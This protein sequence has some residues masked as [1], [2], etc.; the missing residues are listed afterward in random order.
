M[1]SFFQTQ[2]AADV[3]A[4][5]NKKSDQNQK[6]FVNGKEVNNDVPVKISKIE[7]IEN[8]ITKEIP[9]TSNKIKTIEQ[10]STE[11]SQQQQIKTIIASTPN[12]SQ[13]EATPKTKADKVDATEP[14]DSVESSIVTADY[15]QQSMLCI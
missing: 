12:S 6:I 1:K 13:L 7:V 8:N 5:G 4:I 11:Q 14:N 9:E 3:T 10:K 2:D 15:I